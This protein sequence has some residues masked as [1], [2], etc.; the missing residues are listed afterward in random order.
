MEHTRMGI[1]VLFSIIF[2]LT[3]FL[4]VLLIVGGYVV[5]AI[6]PLTLFQASLL[7]AITCLTLTVS[8]VTLMTISSVQ[9][10]RGIRLA[11]L[12]QEVEEEEYEDDTEEYW[13]EAPH[14]EVESQKSDFGRERNI[15]RNEKCPCGS[16]RKYK[17]CCGS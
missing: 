4:T 9:G 17:N 16:G 6:F 11:S 14:E 5:S 7:L 15:G 8:L 10:I 2:V 13:E 3:L 12:G 1:F